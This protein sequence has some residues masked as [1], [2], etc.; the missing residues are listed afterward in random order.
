MGL[1]QKVC[2]YRPFWRLPAACT[3]FLRLCCAYSQ[4]VPGGKPSLLMSSSTQERDS[5][6]D[7]WKQ[8]SQELE[9]MQ[10]REQVSLVEMSVT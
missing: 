2:R 5:Y 6:I 7:L 8:T 4:F 1:V 10:R 3:L 9:H